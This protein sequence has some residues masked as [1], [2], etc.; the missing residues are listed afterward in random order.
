MLLHLPLLF[1]Y[2]YFTTS[3]IIAINTCRFLYVRHT[4]SMWIMSTQ[5]HTI[6]SRSLFPQVGHNVAREN[7]PKNMK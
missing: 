5:N 1:H 2:Q 4:S 3:A 7:K 6:P